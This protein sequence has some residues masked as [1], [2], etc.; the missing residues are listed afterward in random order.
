MNIIIVGAGT[1]GVGLAEHLS[2]FNYHISVIDQNQSLCEQ[3]N[4]KLDVSAINAVGSDPAA[5]ENAGIGSADMVIAVTP[6]D[7]INL[8]V[9]NIAM[10]NGVEKRIARVKSD[11][12]TSGSPCIDINKVGVTHLIEPEREVVKKIMQYVELPGVIEAANFQSDSIYLRGY[13]IT[14]DMPI[15]NKTLIQIKSM[16]QSSPML[17]VVITRAG[18]SIPPTGDQKLLPGDKVVVITPKESFDVFRNS[19]INRK[20]AKLKKIVVSGDSLT[21]IHLADALKPLCEQVILVDPDPEHGHMAASM[22]NG[23]EV[24]NGDSTE[25]DVLREI[26]VGNAD[27]FIAAGEDTEDNIMSCLLAKTEG[28]GRVMAIRN[29]DRY[30]ALFDSLGIDYIITPQQLTLNV[31]ME[32]IQTVSIATYLKLKTS[33]IEVIRLRAVNKSQVI[34]KSLRELDNVFKKSVIIGCIIRDNLA[35]IPDGN[36]TIE[37]NDEAIV[38]CGKDL[39]ALVNKWFGP[40]LG[41]PFNLSSRLK[42]GN[43]E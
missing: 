10:Q 16:A 28:T 34:G 9:C 36:T 33:G 14:D 6:S 30:S 19:L 25:S 22:L 11:L 38:L 15:A 13:Q 20:P 42:S 5:L 23:V 7:E 17:F 21:A 27:Y 8:L 32:K 2:N 24:L 18:K 37:T 39:I 3:I 29:D 41:M 40:K 43:S 26:N 31:I 4:S 1:V 12:Y 35:I